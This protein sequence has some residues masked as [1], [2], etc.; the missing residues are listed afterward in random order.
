MGITVNSL[1]SPPP[2]EVQVVTR[3]TM[4][5]A[6]ATDLMAVRE[7]V[8]LAKHAQPPEAQGTLAPS[9]RVKETMARAGLG[10]VPAVAVVARVR[11]EAEL[12]AEAA[13]R[14]LSRELR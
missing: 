5:P 11:R 13:R 4:L 6:V 2:E 1:P 7:V 3:L 12:S 9:L 10:R 14:A 8:A